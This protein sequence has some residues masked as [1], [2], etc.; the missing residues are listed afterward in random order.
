MPIPP[1]TRARQTWILPSTYQACCLL[2]LCIDWAKWKRLFL[3]SLQSLSYSFVYFFIMTPYHDEKVKKK[4]NLIPEYLWY[5]L[6]INEFLRDED[7]SREMLMDRLRK[8]SIIKGNFLYWC[9]ISDACVSPRVMLNSTLINELVMILQI[10][11]T[12]GPTFFFGGGRE[13]RG[14]ICHH[15]AFC[16]DNINKIIKKLRINFT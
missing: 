14:T 6:E 1:Q 11:F 13:D 16:S 4:K 15:S 2:Q 10:D 5:N 3:V 12:D 7:K 8:L 9:L